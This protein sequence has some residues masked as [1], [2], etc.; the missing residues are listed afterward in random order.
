MS[1]E[2]WESF[3]LAE[4]GAAAA[5]GGL[6]FVALS[7]NVKQIVESGGLADRALQ[8]LTVL[9]GILILG[10]LLLMPDQTPEA[11]GVEVL[12]VTV[13]VLALGTW[14]GGRGFRHAEAEFRG[15]FVINLVT[16]EAAQ[17]P[18]LAGGILLIAFGDEIG[19]YLVA[20]GI[21]FGFIKAVSD[22]WVFLV[23]INR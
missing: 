4:V 2:T 3:F 5:L 18:T 6:L 19:L 13:L 1:P 22:A 9:V 16:F 15:R 21:C 10:S 14:F 12:V 17:I 20:I 11:I 23:E 7:I 8:A